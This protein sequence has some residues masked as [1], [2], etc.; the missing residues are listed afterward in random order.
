MIYVLTDSV[1][2]VEQANNTLLFE[3]S[4][5]HHCLLDLVCLLFS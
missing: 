2:G 4:H 3:V 5:Y 1:S